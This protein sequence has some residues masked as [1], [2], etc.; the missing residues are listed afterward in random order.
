MRGEKLQQASLEGG[1]DV[2]A[3]GSYLRLQLARQIA[4]EELAAVRLW[5]AAGHRREDVRPRALQHSLCITDTRKGR[6]LGRKILEG[7]RSNGCG[8]CSTPQPE[9]GI[10]TKVTR[11]S[12][13]D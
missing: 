3:A 4:S 1:Q 12:R 9:V 7:M 5:L 2:A 13:R 10:G 11:R 8:I 6:K